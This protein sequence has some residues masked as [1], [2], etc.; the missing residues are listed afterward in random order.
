MKIQY[1]SDL[2]LEF[3]TNE[4]FVLDNP[5]TPIGDILVLAGDIGYLNHYSYT[6]HPFW[7]WVSEN[8]KEV[9]V[10]VGNHELYQYYD[11]SSLP[12]G[13]VCQIRENVRCYYNTVV[14]YENTDIIISTLW[15]TILPHNGIIT[16]R[17]VADFRRIKYGKHRLTWERF[18]QEH[19]QCVNFIK[20]SVA[21]S[22][23]E[24]IVVATH[25]VPSFLVESPDFKGSH[26]N[27]AF[28]TE[29][30][31]YIE[32][33]RIDYWIYG[34]SHRNIDTIIGNTKCISNQLGYVHMGEHKT[35]KKD[36]YFTL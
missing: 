34:H 11:L 15:A 31:E 26:I 18:N 3:D 9:I 12:S 32:S 29:L 1:A 24:N 7:D 30:S 6:A 22:A 14:N 13:E 5:L 33:S 2:H 21:E 23:A 20:K 19:K 4:R 27:G 8:Y 28:T 36:A 17:S 35:F 10:V 16:E 25:H